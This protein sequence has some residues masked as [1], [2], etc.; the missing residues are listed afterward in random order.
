MLARELEAGTF[1]YAWTQVSETTQMVF[2]EGHENTMALDQRAASQL[3]WPASAE[4]SLKV[5]K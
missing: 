5:V 4:E 2:T 3:T 1:R